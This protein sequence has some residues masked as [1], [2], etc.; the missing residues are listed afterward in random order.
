M[1]LLV[2]STINDSDGSTNIIP[3]KTIFASRIKK[4][5][6]LLD[7]P[8]SNSLPKKMAAFFK[9]N[10]DNARHALHNSIRTKVI[11]L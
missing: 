7:D 11:F 9:T 5:Q 2:I 4:H 6:L 8:V 3:K 1:T 10:N